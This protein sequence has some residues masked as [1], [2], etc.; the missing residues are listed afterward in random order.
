MK[1]LDDTCVKV[2]QCQ[3]T[4]GYL[5]RKH[6]YNILIDNNIRN[7]IT[8]LIKEPNK[9]FLYAID[10]YW[11]KLQQRDNWFLIT[12]LTVTQERRL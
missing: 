3:T 10:K 12:P 7:G 8:N 11:F 1:L 5:V 2:T 9:H 6:Y 4:T